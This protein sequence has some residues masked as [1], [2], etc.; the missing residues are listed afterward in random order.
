M[1]LFFSCVGISAAVLAANQIQEIGFVYPQATDEIR[2]YCR[3][4]EL[5]QVARP[6]SSALLLL[7]LFQTGLLHRLRRWSESL[8][9]VYFLGFLVFLLALTLILFAADL[10]YSFYLQYILEHNVGL[11]NQTL[12][13]YTIE[14]LKMLALQ[15]S[16]SLLIVPF[17]AIV[18]RQQKY[19]SVSIWVLTGALTAL[20]IFLKPLAI[21]PLF[22]KFNEM[23]EA[24]SSS[25]KTRIEDLCAKANLV[26]PQLYIVDRSKQSKKIN[27]YVT[28]IAGSTR[29]VLYDTLLKAVP[30]G[31]VLMVVAH[32]IAH[33]KF[34]HIY[35]GL[36][37]STVGL[38]PALLAAEFLLAPQIPRLPPAWGI[39]SK[40]DPLFFALLLMAI[41][42][43]SP[44]L[45]P[46][47]CAISRYM[48]TE[49]DDYALTL[50]P[51]PITAANLF[52]H[53][54]QIDMADPDPPAIIEF[55]LYTHPSIKHRIDRA[56]ERK[57]RT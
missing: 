56:L 33:Y 8:T 51:D 34:K 41:Q 4:R 13:D 47:E 28:G 15:L 30:E 31:E 1:I 45:S 46:I 20:L 37:L 5:F 55:W 29:I 36:L 18:R 24:K 27:A 19:W 48:E 35:L 14:K 53:L 10:P 3:Q 12:P 16:T 23:P 9:P 22:N 43:S 6:I 57:E 26:N 44:L 17:A 50:R 25:L 2:N 49:A 40:S 21:D 39:R 32:E 38:L 11:S 42:A 7:I 52:A 54:S